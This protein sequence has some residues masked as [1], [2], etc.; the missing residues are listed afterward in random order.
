MAQQ[1][2]QGS[3]EMNNMYK[4]LYFCHTITKCNQTSAFLGRENQWP[5]PQ[6]CLMEKPLNL[7][8]PLADYRGYS[9]STVSVLERFVVLIIWP[10]KP[11]SKSQ[12]YQKSSGYLQK[13]DETLRIC[14]VLTMHYFSTPRELPTK[15]DIVGDSAWNGMIKIRVRYMEA[16][17]WSTLPWASKV[18]QELCKAEWG[19]KGRWKCFF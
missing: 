9:W 18:Y 2:R 5:G 19:C 11:E 1:Y 15:M 6:G 8:H 4:V 13:R 14:P 7:L 3:L 10:H 17:F 12:W 16:S